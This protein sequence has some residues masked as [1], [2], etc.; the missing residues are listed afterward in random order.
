MALP[1]N[2]RTNILGIVAVLIVLAVA[3]FAGNGSLF[4]SRVAYPVPSSFG[5]PP[6][7]TWPVVK[8]YVPYGRRRFVQLLNCY[9]ERNLVTQGGL[10]S[11]VQAPRQASK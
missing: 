2:T 11:E 1:A 4:W 10:I 5:L 7:T 3:C 9:L 6:G 8:A